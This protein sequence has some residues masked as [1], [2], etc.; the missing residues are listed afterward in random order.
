[1]QLTPFLATALLAAGAMA[2]PGEKEHHVNRAA[3]LSKREFKAAARRGLDAC[4]SKLNARGG[5]VDAAAQ[6]RAE[7]AAAH[8]K[9]ALAARGEKAWKRDTASVLA[10]D[11]NETALGYTTDTPE[12]TIFA[13]NNTCILTTEGETGPYWVKGEL[14]RENLREDQGGVPVVLEAQFLD[15]ETCEPITDLYW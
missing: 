6:R 9:R 10:T 1:M 8:S 15:V 12:T 11:H 13:T 4:A 7:K 3:E 5:L 2:H 14:V